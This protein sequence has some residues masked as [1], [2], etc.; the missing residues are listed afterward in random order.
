ELR[1]SEQRLRDYAEIASDWFWES[2]PDH[3]FSVFSGKSPDWG[4][5]GKFIGS[6]RWGVAA[7]REDE[8]EKGDAH[9]AA[10]PPHQPFRGFKYRIARPDGTP[11]YVSVG[12]K[13]LFAADGKFMGY[14]GTASDVT[15]EVRAEQAEHALR[16]AQAELAHVSRVMTMGELSASIA[17][18]LN[19]PI[20]AIL[21][22]AG[23]AMNWL[24][25]PSPDL[26]ETREALEHIVKS[27]KRAAR[28]IEQIRAHVKKAPVQKIEL[29]INEVILE[30]TALTRAEI[31]RN[32]VT[33]R[34]ELDDD[35]PP[36]QTDRIE[37]QQV[38]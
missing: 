36:V 14:R 38:M 32:H 10:L 3:R 23:A 26:P 30:V 20:A 25:R 37:F 4:V 8:P 31:Q 33:L 9:L 5:S 27:T 7:D 11:L 35:L 2:G 28:V 34:T 6:T 18:E 16:E 29:N 1:A 21:S 15:A 24:A 13:P 17:H 22:E 19:Q 12:G